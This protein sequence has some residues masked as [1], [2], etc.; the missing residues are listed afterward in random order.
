MTRLAKLERLRTLI[1]LRIDEWHH[2]A[3]VLRKQWMRIK[4]RLWTKRDRRRFYGHVAGQDDHYPLMPI[5][6]VE[7]RCMV[8]PQITCLLGG[9]FSASDPTPE[10]A[11][12][13]WNSQV[14]AMQA[15]KDARLGGIWR[16]SHRYELG[17]SDYAEVC[18]ILQDKGYQAKIEHYRGPRA[19]C[20]TG[21]PI[22]GWHK[23]RANDSYER[24]MRKGIE[25]A[26]KPIQAEEQRLLERCLRWGSRSYDIS[27][28]IYREQERLGRDT[29]T[30]RDDRLDDSIRMMAA[31]GEI[32]E[33][34]REAG[35]GKNTRASDGGDGRMDE[36]GAIAC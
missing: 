6:V 28:A 18:Q 31:I 17:C 12:Q 21:L 16:H 22:Y 1:R 15:L 25:R 2:E 9:A 34:I 32:K 7:F 19:G 36:G 3:A 10:D 11:E 4:R 8:P 5:V 33:A 35:N 30:A 23:C 29:R 13:A 26:R 14:R 27:S 24:A 20:T